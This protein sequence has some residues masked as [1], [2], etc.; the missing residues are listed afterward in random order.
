MKLPPLGT[1]LSDWVSS[2]LGSFPQSESP[3]ALSPHREHRPDPL[4]CLHSARDRAAGTQGKP[5]SLLPK[6]RRPGLP[7]SQSQSVCCCFSLPNTSPLGFRREKGQTLGAFSSIVLFQNSRLVSD[8]LPWFAFGVD[9]LM[10]FAF[11]DKGPTTTKKKKKGKEILLLI[12][13]YFSHP[14][15]ISQCKKKMQTR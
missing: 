8:N 10:I 9:H 11:S 6:L 13:F 1:R 7:L 5:W 15:N 12:F 4:P 2:C 3:E 14:V